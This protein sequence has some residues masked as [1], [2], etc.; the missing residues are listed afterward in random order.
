M[1]ELTR[2]RF[3]KTHMH[4]HLGALQR[5]ERSAFPLSQRGSQAARVEERPR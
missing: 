4:A 2:A 1:T 5:P 3:R